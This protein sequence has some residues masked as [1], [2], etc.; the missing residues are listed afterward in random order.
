M[1]STPQLLSISGMSCAGCVSRVE[2]A[3]REVPGV[4]SATVNFAS[5][6][7][8]VV[9]SPS[10]A[11]LK[12]AVALAGY[13]AERYEWQSLDEQAA[14]A[15]LALLFA[16]GRSSIAL[17]AGGFLML[18]MR[19][20]FLPALGNQVFWS[21]IGGLVL[22]IMFAAGGHFFS[23]AFS[24]LQHKTATMDTL[25]S[26]GTG[27]AWFY[28]ML[29]ILVP[30]ALPEASRHQFFEAALFILGFVN[31]GKAFETN[32][33]VRASLAIQKLFDLTP[34]HVVRLVDDTSEV[35]PLALI[36]RGE[37]LRI[38]P[39]ESVPVDGVVESGFSSVDQAMLSGESKAQAVQPGDRVLAGTLNLDGSLTIR[40]EAVGGE[41]VLGGII[42]LV[43]EAQNSKPPIAELIDRIS[44]IFVPAVVMLSVITF[45]VW[46]FLGPAPQLSFA[47]VTAMSV[48]IIACPCA[49]GLAV[50]MSIMVGLGRAAVKGL[51]VRNSKVL[52]PTA[53]LDLLVVDKTGTLTCG[54][55]VVTSIHDLDA[56]ALSIALALEVR[57]EHP[58]ADAIRVFCE[59]RSVVEAKLEEF[60]NHPGRGVSAR[61]GNMRVV[62]GS[63][64]LLQDFGVELKV[65][66]RHESTVSYL[67]LGDEV[68]GYF[69]LEDQLRH[70]TAN[71]LQELYGQGIEVVMLSGDRQ[72]VVDQIGQSL[73]IETR[74]GNCLPQDKVSYVIDQQAQGR[75]VGMVGDGINDSAA[76][77]RADVGFA[78]GLGS[79]IAK[80]SSDV[81][82]MEGS[83]NGIVKGIALSKQIT[84]N[85]RQNLFAA[86]GYNLV[87]VPVAAGVVYPI[88]GLLVDPALAGMAMALSS[89][90]VV[91]NASRLRFT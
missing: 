21:G 85:I 88:T 55:P 60:A 43:A 64:A 52:E 42:N 51:L 23:S 69:L 74:I 48:L 29:V 11:Q 28:S 6:T 58:L 72:E 44:A 54:K 4:T 49:L 32:A 61:H 62:L 82:L 36:E 1:N 47:L 76:L 89:V 19:L 24:S 22:L 14:R 10:L 84:R 35:V 83:L 34:A 65:H 45:F 25:V 68:L 91:L 78:M 41:T 33:R 70:D 12:S 79:D 3:L 46:L 56:E 31:L 5:E 81:V 86:F 87:L 71:V 63:A 67:A 80:E 20:G 9:G 17:L 77:A 7:A 75:I 59:E 57:S 38:R 66:E 13:A 26:L 30:A 90:S 27:T 15:R 37:M 16:L 8:S 50:P 39:G 18:D 2:G 53:K 40:S 73:N